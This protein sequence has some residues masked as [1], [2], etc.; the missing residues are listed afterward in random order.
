MVT[1][2]QSVHHPQSSIVRGNRHAEILLKKGK[3]QQLHSVC[4][5]TLVLAKPLLLIQPVS[6]TLLLCFSDR[7]LNRWNFS[8]VSSGP[9]IGAYYHE[10]F[11]R[12][13]PHL[14]AQMWCKNARTMLAMQQGDKNGK[15]L[16]GPNA[17]N[18]EGL[19]QSLLPDSSS[20]AP[21]NADNLRRNV[22]LLDHQILLLQRQEHTN[23]LLLERALLLQQ[24]DPLAMQRLQIEIEEQKMQQDRILQMRRLMQLGHQQP[25]RQKP[26]QPANN[27]ASAA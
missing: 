4:V 17:T 23:R 21:T 13:K 10:F 15:K 11:L 2:R 9:E 24:N 26:R 12:D 16:G 3:V 20:V 14:A 22:Q 5:E 27:R 6:L 18:S 7:K 25:R 1:S 19:G 8:R